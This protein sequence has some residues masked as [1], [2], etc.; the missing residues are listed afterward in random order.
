MIDKKQKWPLKELKTF[1]ETQSLLA[2]LKTK[3]CFSQDITQ[4]KSS[5]RS[6]VSNL[7]SHKLL[8][9]RDSE[10]THT[11]GEWNVLDVFVDNIRSGTVQDLDDRFVVLLWCDQE[12]QLLHLNCT[13]SANAHQQRFPCKQNSNENWRRTANNKNFASSIYAQVRVNETSKTV[14]VVRLYL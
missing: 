2:L 8:V 9:I 11:F 12:Q 13:N 5:L 7:L 6:F 1:L 4:T 14:D 10:I 3:Q